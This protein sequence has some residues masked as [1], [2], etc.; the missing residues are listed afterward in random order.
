MCGPEEYPDG[1]SNIR[2][3]ISE[4]WHDVRHGASGHPLIGMDALSKTQWSVFCGSMDNLLD[5]ED[6]L[7]TFW[8]FLEAGGVPSKL[9]CLGFLSALYMQQDSVGNISKICN[10][11]RP[12]FKSG[13]LKDIREIRNRVAGHASHAKAARPSGSAMWA[14]EDILPEGFNVVLYYDGDCSH[15]VIFVNFKEFIRENDLALS[16]V[17]AVALRRLSLT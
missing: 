11:D 2:S 8:R 14:S 15:E 17:L 12:D 4:A 6:A 7:F 1:L 13:I 16:R 5:M 3:R 9:E 10:V